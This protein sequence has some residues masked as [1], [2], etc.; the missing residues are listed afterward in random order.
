[1]KVTVI[2]HHTRFT[3]ELDWPDSATSFEDFLQMHGYS[4][5]LYDRDDFQR[6]PLVSNVTVYK[7][8]GEPDSRN[9]AFWLSLTLGGDDYDVLCWTVM[10]L[11]EAFDMVRLLPNV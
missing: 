11:F 10:D 5:L 6:H 4:T 2:K 7:Y 1:M 8:V 3:K 9:A